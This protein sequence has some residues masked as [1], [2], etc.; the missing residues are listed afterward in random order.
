MASNFPNDKWNVSIENGIATITNKSN[1]DIN[2]TY[3]T[4]YHCYDAMGLDGEISIFKFENSGSNK[5][6]LNDCGNTE[7][8]F[9]LLFSHKFLNVF[10]NVC[11]INGNTDINLLKEKWDDIFITPC[12]EFANLNA[13]SFLMLQNAEADPN[14]DP[15]QQAAALYEY[16]V[17]KYAEFDFSNR[18]YLERAI[19]ASAIKF[20]SNQLIYDESDGTLICI[21]LVS[22]FALLSSTFL[23]IRKKK[24]C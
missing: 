2:L 13:I 17:G 9:A 4:E 22:S 5:V 16:I 12:D 24:N 21:L 6:Y 23:L 15:I 8:S 19:P 1:N 3:D 10:S 18:N 7:E 20:N 14:G 11:D